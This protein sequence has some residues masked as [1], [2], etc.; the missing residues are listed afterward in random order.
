MSNGRNGRRGQA[1]SKTN[2]R[3]TSPA[4]TDAFLP[5]DRVQEIFKTNILTDHAIERCQQRG[6]GVWE[7]ASAIA[8]PDRSQRQTHGDGRETIAYMR[9]DVKVVVNAD[10]HA[11]ITV[12][13]RNADTRTEP[14]VPLTPLQNRGG[15]RM[16]ARKNGQSQDEAW[17]L[18]PHDQP[19]T[20]L[21]NVT[22]A[23]AEKLL[24]FNVAN[25]PFNKNLLQQY[26]DDI[27]AGD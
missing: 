27:L 24:S 22:P 8:E 17:C 13:D 18:T 12:A 26:V 3:T 23:L 25:R 16:A 14:R 9:G 5:S 10:D 6:I 20:R 1:R 15:L 19:E 21:V 4:R 11:I 7:I 2:V